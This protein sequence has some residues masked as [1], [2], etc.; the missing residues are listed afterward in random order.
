MQKRDARSREVV[1][2]IAI[3]LYRLLDALGL[4]LF[5]EPID[6]QL[7]E[8]D[9]VQTLRVVEDYKPLDCPLQGSGPSL[10]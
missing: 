7:D 3:A 1:A 4:G 10:T 2:F 5:L 6:V 8:L 9:V